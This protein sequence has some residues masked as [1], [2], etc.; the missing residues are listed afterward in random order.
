L[1][2]AIRS[3]G[4]APAI[5]TRVSSLAGRSPAQ[6]AE[7][8]EALDTLLCSPNQKGLLGIRDELKKVSPKKVL[9][10][11]VSAPDVYGPGFYCWGVGAD[12]ACATEIFSSRPPFNAFWF[13]GRGMLLPDAKGGFEPTLGL[14]L[15]RQAMADYALAARCQRLAESARKRDV[16]AAALEKV[17]MTIRTTADARPPGF[18][19][20]RFRPAAVNP[21][22][23]RDWRTALAREAG[24]L[25]EKMAKPSR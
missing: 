10:V 5:S 1:A 24:K 7:L 16:D 15:F 25:A 4:G 23:L 9:L 2:R 17:L 18:D 6:R 21:K 20:G 3:A 11:R 22:I 8:F 13:D 12:G 14:M 19:T